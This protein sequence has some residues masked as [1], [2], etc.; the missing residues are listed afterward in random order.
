MKCWPICKVNSNLQRAFSSIMKQAQQSAI[1][2][3]LTTWK[4]RLKTEAASS[5]LKARAQCPTKYTELSEAGMTPKMEPP[6]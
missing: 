5:D 3:Q 2:F 6:P 1:A 4:A